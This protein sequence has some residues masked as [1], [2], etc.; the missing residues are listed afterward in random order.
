L[1]QLDGLLYD[2][3]QRLAPHGMGNPTPVFAARGLRLLSPPRVL[4]ERHL[5]LRVGQ[6]SRG[7]DA[8]AWG[9]GPRSKEWAQGQ[10]VDAA[11]TLEANDFQA[12]R[13]LQ[14][15]LRDMRATNAERM[16]AQAVDSGESMS[17]IIR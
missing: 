8:L 6:D 3:L 1:A 7:L 16:G 2:N 4:K 15:E 14:L 11:F 5:K 12:F 13:S 9:W 17:P 10:T